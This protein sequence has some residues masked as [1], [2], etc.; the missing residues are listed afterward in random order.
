[1]DVVVARVL[2]PGAAGRAG[3]AATRLAAAFFATFVDLMGV[4]LV[5]AV[6]PADACVMQL[7]KHGSALRCRQ[8]SIYTRQHL[9]QICKEFLPPV[10]G[11]LVG[12]LLIRPEARLLH[13]HCWR[14]GARARHDLDDAVLCSSRRRRR[15]HS[16]C[17]PASTPMRCWFGPVRRIALTDVVYENRWAQ[18]YRD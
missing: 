18:P 15:P 14:R 2:A 10:F 8:T 1:M 6:S 16:D 13:A 7:C 12:L 9:L 11:A 17:R 4:L 5:I 3:F